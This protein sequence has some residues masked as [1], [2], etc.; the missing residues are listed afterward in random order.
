MFLAIKSYRTTG[1]YPPGVAPFS[2]NPHNRELV[3]TQPLTRS[4][5]FLRLTT[6]PTNRLCVI[7]PLDCGRHSRRVRLAP[8]LRPI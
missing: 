6:R 1:D 2:A 7:G 8:F 5:Q 4:C 3:A